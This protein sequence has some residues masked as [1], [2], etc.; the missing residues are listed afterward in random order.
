MITKSHF[1]LA[2]DCLLKLRH[3]LDGLEGSDDDMLRL[4]SEGGGALEAL[5]EAL[6][7]ADFTGPHGG[8]EAAAGCMDAVR[9]EYSKA[10][11]HGQGPPRRLRETTIVDG[12]FLGRLD[13]LR[14]WKDRIELLEQKSKSLGASGDIDGDLYA[15]RGGRR[16]K[17]QWITYFQDIGFQAELL[18]RWLRTNANSLGIPKDIPVVPRLLVVNTDGRAG[19]GDCLPNFRATY[20][21][22]GRKVRATVRHTGTP[23]ESSTLLLEID[24]SAGVALMSADAQSDDAPF[25]GRGLAACMDRLE[26]VVRGGAWPNPAGSIGSRCRA[27]EYRAA[28][29]RDSGFVRCWGTD[30]VAPDHILR[31]SRLKQDQFAEAV[32]AGGSPTTVSLTVLPQSS[33]TPTQVKQWEVARSG[34]PWTDARFAADTLGGLRAPTKGAVSFLD[35][36]TVA[37]QIPARIGGAPYEKVPF[38]FEAVSLPSASAPLKD[39]VGHDGFLDLV[40]L[41]PRRDFVRALEAQLPTA[42]CIYHWSPYERVVL[43]QVRGS[44]VSDPAK[45]PD[46]ARLIA[47]IDQVLGRLVDLLEIIR[48]AYLH[49]DMAGSYSIKRVLPSIWRERA[50][51]AE[52][53]PGAAPRDPIAYEAENDP[54]ESLAGLGKPFLEAIGGP[55][56]LKRLEERD[57]TRGITGGGTASLYYH[58]ARQFSQN[59]DPEVQRV[60]RDYCRLDARAMLMVYRHLRGY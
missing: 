60:F 50:I 4:L 20:V 52:F 12:A 14:V 25:K 6:E 38:Q 8:A 32:A 23:P 22:S 56:V 47:A 27:C 39:R 54:Y 48:G 13:L 41:D 17:A 10:A 49:P 21:V 35:F 1:K 58:W 15:S 3:E 55:A 2:L 42:A 19:P 44:L 18:R 36:E 26:Q 30:P 53:A 16:V 33:L 11:K 46:D 59:H 37:F 31:L 28:G 51:R 40:S 29:D 57:D 24:A 43:E 45:Q 7:P 5:S 9:T 34:R